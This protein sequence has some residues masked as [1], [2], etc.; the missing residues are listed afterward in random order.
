MT[1]CK[2]KR[3][4]L[5]ACRNNNNPDLLKHYNRY[6]KILS[7]V[8]KEAKKLH[9][10]DKIKK[11]STKNRTIWNIVHLESNKTDNTDKIS[12]LNINGIP[13]SDCQKMANE[14][15]KYCLAVAKNINTKQNKSNPY[16]VDNITPLHYLTQ[17]FKNPFP[18]INLK[19]VSTKEIKTN[20]IS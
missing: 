19:T 1:S 7:A 4:F 18:N 8:I 9:Y 6:S 10:A 16:N 11:A 5:T 15:N 20:K 14:F 17:S 2:H 3:E 12:T 13:I